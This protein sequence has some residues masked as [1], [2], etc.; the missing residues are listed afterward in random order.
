MYD[1]FVHECF[2]VSIINILFTGF[3]KKPAVITDFTQKPAVITGF[4][5]KPAVINLIVFTS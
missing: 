2:V 4:T 1:M 3:T 5:L